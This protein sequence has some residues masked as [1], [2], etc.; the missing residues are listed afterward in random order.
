MT[1][2]LYER[3]GFAKCSELLNTWCYEISEA[4]SND[5]AWSTD[6]TELNE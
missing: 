2:D 4:V 1:R 5:V 3:I 6:P